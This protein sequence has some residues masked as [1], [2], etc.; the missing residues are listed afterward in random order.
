MRITIV[1][2]III[3]LKIVIT[4]PAKVELAKIEVVKVELAKVDHSRSSVCDEK[5]R[6]GREMERRSHQEASGNPSEA[7]PQSGATDDTNTGWRTARSWQLQQPLRHLEATQLLD[8]AWLLSS[9][10]S[11]MAAA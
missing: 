8:S 9:Y 2:I 11:T 7:R 6:R 10:S 5:T 1:I 4:R 3:I